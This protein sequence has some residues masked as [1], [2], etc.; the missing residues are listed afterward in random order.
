MHRRI[1]ELT[2]RLA[3]LEPFL[4]RHGYWEE[5]DEAGGGKA[6]APQS[7]RMGVASLARYPPRNTVRLTPPRGT[8]VVRRRRVKVYKNGAVRVLQSEK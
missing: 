6:L 1:N 7:M 4:R 8:R 5:G 3:T 2:H